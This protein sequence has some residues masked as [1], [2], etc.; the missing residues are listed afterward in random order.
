MVSKEKPGVVEITGTFNETERKYE[1][2]TNCNDIEGLRTEV[3]E[4]NK[5]INIY[6]ESV[7][8]EKYNLAIKKF[9]SA[10]DDEKIEDRAPET[11]ISEDGKVTYKLNDRI[12]KASNNQ[13]IKYTIRM[14][15]ESDVNAKGKRIVEYIPD[16]LVYVPNNDINKQY[17]WVMYGADKDGQVYK[18]ENPEEA[19]IVVSDYL[20]N[21]KIDARK[22]NDLSYLYTEVVFK[23]D[24][25]KLKTDDRIIENKVIIMPNENDDYPDN[26]ESVEKLYVKY[27][28]LNIEKYIE[29]VKI[30]NKNGETIQKV[31]EDKKNQLLKID[32]KRSEVNSTT[33]TVTY[34]L[35]VKNIGEI[36]G[37]ATKLIDYIPENFKLVE[38]G[39]WSQDGNVAVSTSLEDKLLNPGESTVV[40]VTFE[41]NLSEGTVGSRVNEA[42]IATYTNKYNAVDLTEDNNDKEELLV[43]IKT[44]S[45]KVMYITIVLGFIAI[46]GIGTIFSKKIMKK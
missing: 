1:F 22:G 6:I 23:V 16:G 21:K 15:N 8:S 19:V 27:F 40:N 3:D 46:V 2:V 14:Y 42:K 32:V 18:T 7:K 24:E 34:G 35:K 37:Y 10:I 39:V 31:G 5:V 11:E 20:V 38:D 36:P 17:G 9:I 4:A 43:A 41:W 25:S 30:K 33:I 12:E 45:E 29:Q 26:D 13:N 28:D 44:G